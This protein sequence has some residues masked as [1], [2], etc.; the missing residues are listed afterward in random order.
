MALR[1]KPGVRIHGLRP[2]VVLAL[3][4]LVGS[5]GKAGGYDVTVT[6]GIDGAHS[7]GSL[8]YS[9]AAVDI[10]TRDVP[11]EKLPSI[12][13]DARESLG[14]DFDLVVESDHLH[15]EFEPKLPY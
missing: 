14:A 12:V 3:Q 9:G 15:V 2:E 5:F 13:A 6:A 8:H 7:P 11:K 1:L 4:V 10:R